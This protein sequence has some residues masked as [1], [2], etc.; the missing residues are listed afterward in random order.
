MDTK[1]KVISP[2]LR[3]H[4]AQP[5]AEPRGGGGGGTL[6]GLAAQHRSILPLLSK[7]SCAAPGHNNGQ[8]EQIKQ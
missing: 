2:S 6:F 7:H 5:G 3:R 4:V 1:F 8:R